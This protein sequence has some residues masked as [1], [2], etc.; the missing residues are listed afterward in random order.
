MVPTVFEIRFYS[1]KNLQLP[2]I[3]YEMRGII[4]RQHENSCFINT[5]TKIAAVSLICTQ[6]LKL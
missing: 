4:V 5:T 3:I 1:I 2:T 6:M